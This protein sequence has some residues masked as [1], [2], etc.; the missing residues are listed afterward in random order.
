MLDNKVKAKQQLVFAIEENEHLGVI[1]KAFIV[2][3]T[4]NEQFTYNFRPVNHNTI[5]DYP[6]SLSDAEFDS[7]KFI[8]EYSDD[9]IVK[10]FSKEKKKIAD[11]YAQLS[12]DHFK[13]FVR[14]YVEKSISK[15]IALIIASSIPLFCKGK[16]TNPI[17]DQAVEI[18]KNPAEVVF[19]FTKQLNETHYYQTIKLNNAEISLTNKQA[20]LLCAL[21]CW[22]LLENKLICFHD[23]VDGMKLLPFFN[24]SHIVIPQNTENKYYQTFVFNTIRHFNVNANG[25]S[26]VE[27]QPKIKTIL[28]IETNLRHEPVLV[29]SFTYGSQKVLFHNT[30][31]IL[32]RLQTD[33][34]HYKFIKIRRNDVYE[35]KQRDILIENN[36]VYQEGSVFVLS[37]QLNLNKKSIINYI[38]WISSNIGL[39]KTNEIEVSQ[40]NIVEKYHIGIPEKQIN[41]SKNQ[42]WFDIEV[43]I[44][45]GDLHFPFSK[46]KYYILNDIPEFVLPNGEIAII[47]EEWFSKIKK[48][49]KFAIETTNGM[50][51][52][53]HHFSLLFQL[54]DYDLLEKLPELKTFFKTDKFQIPTIDEKL[55]SVMRNYQKKGVAWLHF[56]QKHNWGGILADDMGL[57]KTIQAIALL[58]SSKIANLKSKEEIKMNKNPYQV[59]LFDKLEGVSINTKITLPSLIIMPLSL[60]HNWE[61]E[62]NKFSPDMKI[63]KHIG[64][65][66]IDNP[67]IFSRYDIILSTYGTIRNDIDFINDFNFHYLILDESQQIKNPFS[68]NYAAIKQINASHKLVLSGTP[69]ENSLNDLW[70]QFSIINPGLLGSLSFFKNEFTIPIEKN[71]DEASREA[72][73]SIIK[74]FILRRTKD[75]VA[76]ELPPLTEKYHFCEMTE[77]QRMI[78]EIKKSEIRNIIFDNIENTGIAKSKF[79]ILSG[80]MKLRLLAIHPILVTKD[81]LFDSGKFQE[82]LRNLENL[83]AENHKVL[84]FSPFVKHLRLFSNYFDKVFYSY[85]FLSGDTDYNGRINAINNFQL[86]P[87]NQF[88]LISIKAGGVGLNLTAADYVFV[89]DPWWNP[90]VEM[91]AIN[92]AHR[93]GQN[94]KVLAYKFITKDTIEEKIIALQQKK[95]KL[96][97]D[98]LNNNNPFSS[99]SKQELEDLFQ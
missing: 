62:I 72:L 45:F 7:L 53:N 23:N 56:L 12:E 4:A 31:S 26:I 69:I 27:E 36:L 84:I 21:P 50:K 98:L 6:I 16:R 46:L 28:N 86:N 54:T 95:Q 59:G 17:P 81:Y 2:E 77:E 64:N 13:R 22:L 82:V 48:I 19:N 30:E 65:N 96:A 3:L 70:S 18:I 91:Q 94:K 37:E 25:F 44:K 15:C 80:L 67:A 92:R 35:T 41:I 11:F 10:K 90:A 57:G 63:Y 89:L 55:L 75:E 29:L 20:L 1:I 8:D 38:N 85:S 47:S 9:A 73:K 93:I 76:K 60:I 88:F 34:N 43:I 61:N 97:F 58:Q 79:I 78:Y 49:A 68:K 42:D 5:N 71:N 40:N 32:L 39:L 33:N 24:K 83:K 52:K 99:L 87:H 66:R 51:L 74:P 14:P